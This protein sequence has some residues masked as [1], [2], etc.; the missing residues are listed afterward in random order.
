MVKRMSNLEKVCVGID[1]DFRMQQDAN[2]MH[3]QHS[4]GKTKSMD[5]MV[6]KE[7][8]LALNGSPRACAG[9]VSALGCIG[10]WMSIMFLHGQ[11]AFMNLLTP[12]K[13]AMAYVCYIAGF[14]SPLWHS[15]NCVHILVKLGAGSFALC[16]FSRGGHR[17]VRT[18]AKCCESPDSTWCKVKTRNERNSAHSH[19]LNLHLPF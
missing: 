11:A 12:D 19:I 16:W 8:L 9:A 5:V 7:S 18:T 14:L 3:D 1:R 13:V 4:V 6:A 2:M 17:K 15:A 10:L